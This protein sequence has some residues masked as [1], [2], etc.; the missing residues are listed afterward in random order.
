MFK[1]KDYA[2]YNFRRYSNPWVAAVSKATG[3]I[4]FTQRIGGYTGGYNKGEAGSL[5]LYQT[6]DE[7]VV[8]AYGQKDHRGNNTNITYAQYRDGKLVEIEKT[9]LVEA[10]T[11]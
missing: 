1:I 7:N 3:K 10:L 11:R 8:I 4:D 5:Y 9:E 2:S 6:P